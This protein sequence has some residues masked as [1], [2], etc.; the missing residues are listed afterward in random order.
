MGSFDPR[1]NVGHTLSS[2]PSYIISLTLLIAISII[3]LRVFVRR[4][5][6]HRGRLSVISAAL[7]TGVFF[8]YGGFP[9]IYLPCEWPVSYINFPIRVICLTCLAIGLVIM[10]FGIFRLGVLRSFGLQTGVLKENSY[11]QVTRNPQ[12]L[13]CVLYVI[14]FMILWPSWFALGWGLSLIFILHVMVL[15]EEEHL[16]NTLGQAYE[17]YC[18]KVPRYIGFVKKSQQDN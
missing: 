17:R 4:D 9:S 6:L 1:E 7:Q 15:T 12:I 16:S 5:Y 14:G 18:K 10:L 11:Y 2:Y 3:V 8:A 13:G